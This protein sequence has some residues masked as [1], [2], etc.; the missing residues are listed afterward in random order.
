MPLDDQVGHLHGRTGERMMWTERLKRDPTAQ[1]FEMVLQISLLPL[2]PFRAAHAW[3]DGTQFLQIPVGPLTIER[4]VLL[5]ELRRHGP[6]LVSV[7]AAPIRQ[8][9][10][11]QTHGGGNDDVRPRERGIAAFAACSGG[12][13]RQAELPPRVPAQHNCC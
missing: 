13:W 5:L 11:R 3:T 6:L 1:P 8:A 4:N 10:E 9:I 12:V 2:H 7:A